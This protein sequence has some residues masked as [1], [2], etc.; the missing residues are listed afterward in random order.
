MNHLK[1][2]CE[3]SQQMVLRELLNLLTWLLHH[4]GILNQPLLAS[5]AAAPFTPQV[6]EG[7]RAGVVGAHTSARAH[8]CVCVHVSMRARV[9]VCMCVCVCVCVC[10]CV[11][12]CVRVHVCMCVYVSGARGAHTGGTH[13]GVHVRGEGGMFTVYCIKKVTPL[14]R[15]L[16][17]LG[18]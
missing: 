17:R 14:G 9:R 4:V 3:L 18:G 1:H 12:V 16:R 2:I 7:R 13:E 15:G 6:G 10:A 5:L 8:V 11:R